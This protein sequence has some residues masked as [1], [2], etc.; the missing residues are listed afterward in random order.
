MPKVKVNQEA[1]I[2]CGVC[3]SMCP[4][5]FELSP[6]GKSQI[7]EKFRGASPAE[8]EIPEDLRSC[9]EGAADNC[10]VKAIT[11]E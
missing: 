9:V 4:D 7:V 5:V 1:C 10:P 3:V 6:E 2:G 8:G 11:I